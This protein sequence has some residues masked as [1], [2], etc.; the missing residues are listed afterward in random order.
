MSNHRAPDAPES[1]RG[2]IP[3]PVAVGAL[4]VIVGLLAVGVVLSL[5]GQSETQIIG[6]LMGL[7]TVAG[8]LLTAFGKLI[9]DHRSLIVKQDKQTEILEQVK[10]NT[11]G[12]LQR[13]IN[14]AVSQAMLNAKQD[15]EI[16]GAKPPEKPESLAA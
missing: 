3:W 5:A 15:K 16:Q 14:Q 1:N 10:W 6:L 7:A 2:P 8:V 12:N 13:I 4:V 11:N 9:T